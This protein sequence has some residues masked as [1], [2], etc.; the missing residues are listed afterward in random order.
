MFLKN[1]IIIFKIRRSKITDYA[2]LKDRSTKALNLVQ[3]VEPILSA[4]VVTIVTI[5]I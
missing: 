5:K 2:A 4:I 3:N 1:K